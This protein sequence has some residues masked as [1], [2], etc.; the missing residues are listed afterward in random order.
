MNFRTINRIYFSHICIWYILIFAKI[1]HLSVYFGD[2]KIMYTHKKLRR[3]CLIDKI[4]FPFLEVN[5]RKILFSLWTTITQTIYQHECEWKLNL[6]I[7]KGNIYLIFMKRDSII[8]TC[9]HAGSV[10]FGIVCTLHEPW[11]T[12]VEK[13]S[14]NIFIRKYVNV[15]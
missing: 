7:E 13:K 15:E 4:T 6:W 12:H 1:V 5:E 11:S 8:I 14:H 10:Y 3:F 2:L 9:F